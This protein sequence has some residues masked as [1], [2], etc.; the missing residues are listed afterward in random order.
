MLRCFQALWRAVRFAWA[1]GFKDARSS[2]VEWAKFMECFQVDNLCRDLAMAVTFS[3]LP[4]VAGPL[5]MVVQCCV[6]WTSQLAV[7]YVISQKNYHGGIGSWL[8][9]TII[10]DRR[11]FMW[12]GELFDTYEDDITKELI[13]S[14]S[15]NI[16]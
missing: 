4:A 3:V 11:S 12:R 16:V 7:E 10:G 5:G 1:K 13:C 14:I 9:N 8:Y 6:F 2:E 15:H